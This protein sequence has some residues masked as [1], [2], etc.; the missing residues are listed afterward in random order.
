MKRRNYLQS[1][2]G[3]GTLP[4]V[5]DID[6]STDGNESENRGWTWIQERR[7]WWNQ[8]HDRQIYLRGREDEILIY[9]PLVYAYPHLTGEKVVV[10]N[11][12]RG[13]G[14]YKI[15]PW[16]AESAPA[17]RFGDR[18][19]EKFVWEEGEKKTIFYNYYSVISK[20]KGWGETA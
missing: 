20:E 6:S 14:L 5:P 19:I 7:M 10:R 17:P 15:E 16:D 9:R 4:F 2:A 8:K 1:V 11:E 3:V 18:S 12:K 13:R